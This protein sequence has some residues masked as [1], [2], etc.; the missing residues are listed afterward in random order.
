M[1]QSEAISLIQGATRVL[2]EMERKLAL[3][4]DDAT[5]CVYDKTGQIPLVIIRN[6]MIGYEDAVKAAKFHLGWGLTEARDKLSERYEE[7]MKLVSA[8]S[9]QVGEVSDATE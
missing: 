1:N 9:F 2:E 8:G 7:Y 4:D 6:T 3:L 5:I